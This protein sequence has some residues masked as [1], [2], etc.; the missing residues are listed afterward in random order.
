M[1]F[2]RSCRKA[3]L[4]IIR[5]VMIDASSALSL[6]DHYALC[7]WMS[8]CAACVTSSPSPSTAT[9]GG[10]RRRCYITQPALSRSI[11]AL[12]ARGRRRPVR[13]PPHRG[14]AHRHGPPAL[15]PR[16]GAR[17]GRPRP[18]PRGPPGQGPGARRAADRGRARGVVP[19]SSRRSSVG[20]TRSTPAAH[21]GRRRPVA[22]AARAPAGPGRR[23]RGRLGSARSSSSTTSRSSAS[24]EHDVVVVCRAGH[25][26]SVAGDVT[27]SDVFEF[28]LVG[29]GMDADAAELLVGL[30]G[31]RAGSTGRDGVPSSSPSSATAPTS[32]SGCCSSPTPLTF[33]P[34]FVVDADVRDGATGH[35]DRGRPRPAGP[36]RRGVAAAAGR[37]AERGRAFLDLLRAH[38]AACSETDGPKGQKGGR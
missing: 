14:R 13:S 12:E 15:A 22:R 11:Q 28:P 36:L 21:A 32:S 31:A 19:C 8:S 16:G 23:H 38:D 6:I 33:L 25:P 18:R 3:V 29:P 7:A 2:L 20:S 9:S 26:L 27:L 1:W 10:R 5:M 30:A 35:P 24:T 34:R 4:A 37:S 17:G